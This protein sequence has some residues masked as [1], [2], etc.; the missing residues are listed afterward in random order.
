MWYVCLQIAQIK[1]KNGCNV[2][3]REAVD[4]IDLVAKSSQSKVCI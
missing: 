2:M 1:F 4:Q 3:K